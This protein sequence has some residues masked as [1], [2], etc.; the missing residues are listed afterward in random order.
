MLIRTK[1]EGIR[2]ARTLGK[3]KGMLMRG[4]GCNVVGK[5]IPHAVQA[6]I[7]LRNNV[8]MQLAAQQLGQIKS[9]SYEEAR[10]A[11]VCTL[12]R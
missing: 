7:E 9:I 3:S 6:L 4:H 8:A 12:C 1:E 10:L 2:V 11:H 5:S